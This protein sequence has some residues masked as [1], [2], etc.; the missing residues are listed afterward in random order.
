MR[1]VAVARIREGGLVPIRLPATG[2]HD[3]PTRPPAFD[4][5]VGA[6][7]RALAVEPAGSYPG[8]ISRELRALE[9]EPRPR[10]DSDLAALRRLLPFFW[11]RDDRRFRLR[12][13]ATVATFGL[14]A[15]LNAAVPLLFARAV[16]A[17]A[18][19][20]LAEAA[21]AILAAYVVGGW[22]AKLLNEVR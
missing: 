16:D 1:G 21:L 13:V 17:F 6:A 20:G 3:L 5:L 22:I 19:P 4:R 15:L 9:R 11:P 12:L 7:A 18:A 8:P 14:A 10:A 2:D